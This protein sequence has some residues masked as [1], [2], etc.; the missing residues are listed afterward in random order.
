MKNHRH[1]LSLLL[2]L[3]SV[4]N[5]M[6]ANAQQNQY[7][8]YNY[9]NDGNF[10][11]WLNIDVDS[12]T[13]S[14]I[15][16]LGV[17]HDD[18]VVQEVWTP[19]SVYRI[20]LN[21]I[22]SLGFYAPEPIMRD[23]LFYL[24][25]YH[26]S[27]TVGIDSLI[28]YFDT[29]IR[30]DSL[31]AI[32]QVVLNGT[33]ISPYEEGFAGRVIKIERLSNSIKMECEMIAV[34]DV[35][36]R[37]VLVGKGI[38]E[39]ANNTPAKI[40]RANGDPWI[41]FQETD[42]KTFKNLGD[43]KVECLNGILSITSKD[44]TLV[45][46]YYVY[47]DE[48]FYSMSVDCSLIHHDVESKVTLSIEKIKELAEVSGDIAETIKRLK[49]FKDVDKWLEKILKEQIKDENDES[50]DEIDLI[51]HLWKKANF[52]KSIPIAGP[53]LLDI[54]LGPLLKLKGDVEYAMTLKNKAKQTFHL[55][56]K[57]NTMITLSNPRIALL[58]GA[59]SIK[60]RS[61]F[62]SEPFH[63][64]SI[65]ATA[66]G[67]LSVG[68]TGKIGLS[69]IHKNVVHANLSAQGGLKASAALDVK[70]M[71]TAVDENDW[72]PYE[73]I[74]ETKIKLEKF[75]KAGVELGVTKSKFFTWGAEWEFWSKDV[76][77]MYLVP[78]FSQP[79][80]PTY[81]DG[82]W[83]NGNWNNH[84]VL[85]SLPTKNIP[86]LFLG[87]CKVALR[88]VDEQGKVV[89]ETKEREYRDDGMITWQ[90][91]PL[92]VDL[93]DLTPGKTYRCYPTLHYWNMK[94]AKATP[95]YE[96]TV[97]EPVSIENTS[98]T[99]NPDEVR[100]IPFTGG[101]GDYK[102]IDGDNNVA[103][104]SLEAPEGF[105]AGNSAPGGGGGTDWDNDT[106][107]FYILGKEVGETTITLKDLRSNETTTLNV[108]VSDEV[109]LDLTLSET[110][111]SLQKD[112][113]ATVTITSGSGNY[114]LENSD[115][116]VVVAAISNGDEILMAG[117]KA[118]TATITVTDTKSGQT[119]TI[120]VTVTDGS[121]VSPGE[122]IDLGL[123]SGTLWA[124]CN[125]GATKPE[126]YG[127]YFAWGETKPKDDYSWGTYFDSS[128]NKYN[129]SGGLTE[130]DLEDDA[131]YVN[132]GSN[133]RMPSREQIQELIDNCNWEWTTLNGVYGRK[134]TSKKNGNSIFLPAAGYRYGASL[135]YAGSWGD[136]WS[137]TL[138]TDYPYRA[139]DLYFYS[140]N[141]YCGNGDRC[142]GQSVR[143]VFDGQMLLKNLVEN[144][145]FSLG[146][147]GFTSD[148]E[149]VSEMGSRALYEEGKYAVG[150]SPQ[151][152]HYGFIDHG[153]HTTGTGNMLIVNGH[154]D[155]S[156]YVWKKTFTVEKGKTYEFSAWFMSVSQGNSL[157]K[158]M[159]EY[160]I[161]GETNLGAYDKSENDWE[162]YYWRYTATKTETIE[163]K[164]RT[165]SSAL[166]GNDFAIDD[167]SFSIITSDNSQ[168]GGTGSGS[169]T[170]GDSDGSGTG[171]GRDR[172]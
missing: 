155:N 100:Q 165:M 4:F 136:Y 33:N 44:P 132:W 144:G 22:D 77:V 125:V 88:I 112:D 151:N 172:N 130:L 35:Y 171:G 148:Y 164:I 118:G 102:I 65:N 119:A 37:L 61:T 83:S 75:A 74:K 86:D 66:K 9:R 79:A 2:L 154:P 23:G 152:Y 78:H 143:P 131:A 161:N 47:V 157:N 89:K 147:E 104:A 124:S 48:V 127:D 162:R 170:G 163:I 98:V 30:N 60:G 141:V 15:D 80:L 24:R 138:R 68:I 38:T 6:P 31:P 105:D 133:W 110:S 95:S 53:L 72:T 97:P 55:S 94:P 160:N 39:S 5:L 106:H 45:V 51:E 166:G 52:S 149:F 91:N 18:V 26:A 82:Q 87:S 12:I 96:F 167:I 101:W 13:Y 99:L 120:A 46:G 63:S 113:R 41:D 115:A 73:A 126:E 69:L 145:D 156:K 36:K 142:N 21:A 135:N 8:I 134:A 43:L 129:L 150:T 58:T 42:V 108:T 10:N 50:K 128:Y 137:R 140:G 64:M 159:I 59:A 117:L 71:D 123:P 103:T 40:M 28:L 29:S 57:G 121:D 93:S 67:S 76:G 111:V 14:C 32:G 17:E 168:N 62:D 146:T 1:I 27:H 25:E 54:E 139:Y 34:G 81:K 122:A 158:E 49:D 153:D 11:A 114:T 90:I 20:P 92:E 169:G 107:Y 109:I 16:T 19:D 85:Q 3:V 84:L 56:A 70:Y 7:A 116:E